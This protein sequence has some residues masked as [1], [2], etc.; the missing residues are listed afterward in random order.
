MGLARFPQDT[1]EMVRKYLKTSRQPSAV[2]DTGSPERGVEGV[3]LA[4]TT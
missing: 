4:R 3:I 1:M 2:S